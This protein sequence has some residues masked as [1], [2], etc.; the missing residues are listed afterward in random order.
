[1]VFTSF[2]ETL[3]LLTSSL[4]FVLFFKAGDDAEVFER[5]GVALHVAAA[6]NSRK[7]RRMILPLRVLGS[8]SVKRISS[9][10]ASAPISF[11][12][13]VLSSSFSASLGSLP[14]QRDEGRNRLAFHLVRPADHRGFGD[15]GMGDESR[16]HFHRA[17]PMSG[18]VDHIV[19]AAHDPEVAVLVFARAIAG[20]IHA[21]NLATNTVCS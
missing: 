6:A 17:Q 18:N 7:R 9:G 11:A 19:N 3:V 10:L 1:M 15:L 21:R 14:F 12:T 5:R 13:H 16:F 4:R 2:L 20:E 8:E